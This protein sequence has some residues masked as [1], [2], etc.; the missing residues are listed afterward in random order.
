ML[1]VAS[2]AISCCPK[3]CKGEG[4]EP[5]DAVGRALPPGA[6]AGQRRPEGQERGPESGALPCVLKHGGNS[7]V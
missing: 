7:Q 5:R 1:R 3:P 2:G 6:W 4:R